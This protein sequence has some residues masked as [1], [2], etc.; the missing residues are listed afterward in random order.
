MESSK[1]HLLGFLRKGL[2]SSWCEVFDLAL[3]TKKNLFVKTSAE[4]NQNMIDY[5]FSIM[6]KQ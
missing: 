3:Y 4:S 6:I 1:K 5:Y 2:L